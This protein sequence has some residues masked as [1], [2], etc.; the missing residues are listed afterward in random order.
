MTCVG[1]FCF[2]C[3]LFS[4]GVLPYPGA[5]YGPVRRQERMD[6]SRQMGYFKINGSCYL[7][8]GVH[9]ASL[10]KEKGR[11][12]SQK[13][14]LAAVPWQSPGWCRACHTTGSRVPREGGGSSVRR[15]ALC[16]S[17]S[18]LLPALFSLSKVKEAVLGK[19]FDV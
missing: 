2:L 3:W 17:F 9:L 18:K 10:E 13:Q 16:L 12:D 7:Q 19:A 6:Q 8:D 14:G 5:S 15:P 4:S 11:S 1:L